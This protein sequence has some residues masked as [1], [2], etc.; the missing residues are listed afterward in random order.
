MDRIMEISHINLRLIHEKHAKT[1]HVI[2]DEI[3]WKN[4]ISI[5]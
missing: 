3:F 1:N 4:S 5:F 2:N